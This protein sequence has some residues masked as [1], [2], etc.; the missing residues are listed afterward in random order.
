M[1]LAEPLKRL[2][3]LYLRLLRLRLESAWGKRQTQPELW[4]RMS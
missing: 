4:C 1:V 3:T 2:F